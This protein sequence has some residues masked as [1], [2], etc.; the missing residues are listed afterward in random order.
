M[1]KRIL[2]DLDGVL[3]DFFGH[4][5]KMFC[6][7]AKINPGDSWLPDI[8]G[9]TEEKFWQFVSVNSKDFWF[10]MPLLP[11]AMEIYNLAVN[12]VGTRN[13]GICSSPSRS[14]DAAYWKQ[15]WVE[16]HFPALARQ[17]IITP[18]K[19][20]CSGPRVLLVDDWDKNA[21]FANPLYGGS[22]YLLPRL[23]NQRHEQADKAAV[24][25]KQYLKTWGGP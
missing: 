8:L 24:M 5:I 25:L 20:L 7:G 3:A 23:W 14:S 15:A 22:F 9:M 17:T 18:A 6:P 4:G 13:V 11:D 2:L 19:Y 12:A 16:R 21:E 1:Q 10:D